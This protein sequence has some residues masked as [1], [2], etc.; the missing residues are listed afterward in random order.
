MCCSFCFRFGCFHKQWVL[1]MV[2]GSIIKKKNE[3]KCSKIK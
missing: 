3:K 2:A 1:K